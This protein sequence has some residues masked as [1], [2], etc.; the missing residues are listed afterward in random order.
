MPLIS[1]S[2]SIFRKRSV[3]SHW[4]LTFLL[5]TSALGEDSVVVATALEEIV[6]NAHMVVVTV[7]VVDVAV[8]DHA[9]VADIA[10]ITVSGYPVL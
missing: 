6:E 10:E 3:K 8:A 4:S 9:V 5:W 7:E 1:F 2:V